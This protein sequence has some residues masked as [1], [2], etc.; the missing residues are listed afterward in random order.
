MNGKQIPGFYWDPDKKKYF[1][2]QA[3]H[4]APTGSQY[5]REA[6]KKRKIDNEHKKRKAIIGHRVRRERVQTARCLAP[7]VTR[8]AAEVGNSPVPGLVRKS[9]L[10]AVYVSQLQKQRIC[11]FDAIAPWASMADFVRHGPSGVIVAGMGT[12]NACRILACPPS[13]KHTQRWKYHS[14][15]A[16]KLYFDYRLSSISMCESGHF[17]ATMDSGNRGES[18]LGIGFL[19]Q[20]NAM[21]VEGSWQDRHIPMSRIEDTATLWCSAARPEPENP[22]FAV[23]TSDGLYTVA[24]NP[25]RLTLTRAHIPI[26][27][28]SGGGGRK[29]S[30]NNH[31]RNKGISTDLLAVEWLSGTVIASGFRNSFLYL[32][33]LRSNGHSQRIKHPQSIEQIR[34]IDDYRL[35]VA[36]YRALHMYDLRYPK[37]ETGGLKHRHRNDMMAPAASTAPYLVF[38]DYTCE[39]RHKIDTNQEL[40]LLAGITHNQTIQFYSLADGSVV[41]SGPSL[42]AAAQSSNT[43]NICRILFEE[44]EYPIHQ[45]QTPRVLYAQGSVIQ[46]LEW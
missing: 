18:A 5:S 11:D 2:I 20:M 31:N 28:K 39:I 42:S 12:G 34:K 38:D 14:G 6:V 32:S 44:Y 24:V 10:G 23:G 29:N 1:R 40:G 16:A 37:T 13:S 27:Q 26:P 25:D 9:Q 33:D 45:N 3:N 46:E 19:N 30:S 43:G 41:P 22:L 15:D 7:T 8:L 36:G 35:V 4:V 21:D 17:L